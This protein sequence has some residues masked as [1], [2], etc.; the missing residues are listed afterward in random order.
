MDATCPLPRLPRAAALENKG[1]P[2]S[3]PATKTEVWMME[4]G[5]PLSWLLGG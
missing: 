5:D 1:G 2:A 3:R 4:K